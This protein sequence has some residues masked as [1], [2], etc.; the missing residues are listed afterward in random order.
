MHAV[1]WEMDDPLNWKVWNEGNSMLDFILSTPMEEQYIKHRKENMK[2]LFV[3]LVM[4][5]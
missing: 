2:N 5:F 4:I 1:G 3:R